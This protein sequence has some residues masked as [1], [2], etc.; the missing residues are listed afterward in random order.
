MRNTKIMQSQSIR[1]YA[2]GSVYD[3]LTKHGVIIHTKK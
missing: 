3:P 1:S 2:T